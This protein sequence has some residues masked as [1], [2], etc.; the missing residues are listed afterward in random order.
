MAS[1]EGRVG[2]PGRP[3]HPT[4]W[5]KVCGTAPRLST[6][7]KPGPTS[8]YIIEHG[9]QWYADVGVPHSTGTKIFSLVGKVKN[10]G[11]VE[12]PMGVTLGNI[13]EDIGGGVPGQPKFKA[14]QTGGSLGRHHPL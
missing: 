1:I 14:V 10:S 11:L 8:P 6:T 4:R 3:G 13:V 7:W 5:K 2:E 9:A 12:V